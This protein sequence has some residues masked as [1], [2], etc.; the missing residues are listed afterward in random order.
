[1]GDWLLSL[2]D[3]KVHGPLGAAVVGVAYYVRKHVVHDS[4]RFEKADERVRQLEINH[5][6]KDD[7]NRIDGKID[8]VLRLLASRNV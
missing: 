4:K 6:T 1:M 8:E 2:L 3:W 5:V 7:V